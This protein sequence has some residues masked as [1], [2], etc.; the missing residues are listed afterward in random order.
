MGRRAAGSRADRATIDRHVLELEQDAQR[1][2]AML[3]SMGDAVIATGVD[4]IVTQMN[5]V[6]ASLTGWEAGAA[7]G[8]P[9]REVLHLV[10]EDAREPVEDP[11]ARVL[12]EGAVV[13]LE[14]RTLLVARDGSG[15]TVAGSGAPIRGAGGSASGVVLVFR[16]TGQERAAQRAL[17]D[18]ERRLRTT[19]DGMIE[20]CQILD[21]EWRYRYLNQ[22]AE[23]HN[24][25]PSSE[26]LGRRYAEVWPGI[27]QTEVYRR[28]RR[29]LEERIPDRMENE[30][31][32]PDGSV[33]WFE[34]RIEPVPE[35]VLVLSTDITASR[36]GELRVEH[37]NRVLGA[38]RRINHLIVRVKDPAELIRDACEVLVSTRS[39][40]AVFIALEGQDGV[41]PLVAQQGWIDGFGTFRTRL[42]E[43]W[44]PGCWSLA[45]AS[46]EGVCAVDRAATC[47]GCPLWSGDVSVPAVVA[48]LRHEGREFGVL[49]IRLAPGATADE[50]EAALLNEVADDLG[51]A[52]HA[53][54]TERR[55]SAYAQIVASSADAMALVGRDYAFLD[56]NPTYARFWNRTPGEMVGRYAGDV[57]GEEFFQRVARPGLDAAFL[58]VVTV[59]EVVREVEGLGPRVA[60]VTY[61][62]SHAHDGSVNAVAV[63]VHDVSERKASEARLREN[64]ARLSAIFHHSPVGIAFTRLSDGHIVDANEAFLR[65]HGGTREQLVGR[66]SVELGLWADPEARVA[67]A[68]SL[69]ESGT[70]RDFEIRGRRL[71]GATRDLLVSV[72]RI[73]LAGEVYTLGVLQDVTER[74][75]AEAERGKLEE[76]LRASQK[77]E[78]IGTLAG[79]I[80]HD[81]NNL[82]MVILNYT[83]F[84]LQ[85][86]R[87]EDPLRTDL[88]EV[89]AAGERAATLTRQLLAFSRKQV[90]QPVRLDLNDVAEGLERMLSRIL[91]EDIELVLALEPGAGRVLAD[92]GQVEQV[93]MNLVVN[94]R[95]AMPQGGRLTIATAGVECRA[96]DAGGLEPGEPNECVE[97]SVTDTGTGMDAATQARIF[98]PFFT[99]KEK[100]RGTGL[101]LATTYGIVR[102]SGGTIAVESAPG[103]GTT[104]RVRLPRVRD[105]HL[106][107]AAPV[108]VASG[109]GGERVLVVED[110]ESLR[111]LV[112]RTLESA[113][114]RVLTAHDRESAIAACA[115]G[116]PHLLLTDVVMP[117]EG[118]R[119]IAEELVRA[120]PGL[121]VLYMSGYTDETIAHHGV[122]DTGTRFVA[123]PFTGADL[124]RQVREALDG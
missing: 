20:G 25:R 81:F 96:R 87:E 12:R 69:A 65:I 35:G 55:R 114:Y 1:H 61:S 44:R 111:A 112:R 113:G 122:L 108:A 105:E 39:Y 4:G 109:G 101:G 9:L 30:F 124:L 32:F 74:K 58:G 38:I 11:V 86:L 37:L 45:L 59:S 17:E 104:M 95:D 76:Q 51:L 49:S 47:A 75:E 118:G 22:A 97:L 115:A 6:A 43:G 34:L 64:E 28:I 68:R 116:A 19:L 62:P 79:G 5:P 15:R 41:A 21:R 60:E 31:V 53:M 85:A 29:G 106:V 99:T 73:E 121:K 90:L 119:I 77:L 63:T 117:R 48:P 123:K 18:S 80:A 92:P 56:V 50:E 57:V 110:E 88:L 27:D 46:A 83:D 13:P 70:C 33:G 10:H 78:A 54:H 42:A 102:Q 72:E 66:S 36:R 107:T 40:H 94:A 93:L 52:L 103:R 16:D 3:L 82:L 24:R 23:T 67:M 8:R 98:E 91:G 2:R 26:L 89:R 120:H 7:V 71:D 84:A 100:G 14:P